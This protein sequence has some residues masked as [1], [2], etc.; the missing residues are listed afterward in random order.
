MTQRHN[1]N[2][3]EDDPGAISK[4]INIYTRLPRQKKKG[5]PIWLDL[6]KKKLNAFFKFLISRIRNILCILTYLKNANFY[7]EYTC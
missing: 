1:I 3:L 6:K 4:R 2:E 7:E 5:A